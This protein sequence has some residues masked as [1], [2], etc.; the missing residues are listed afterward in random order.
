[1]YTPMDNYEEHRPMEIDGPSHQAPTHSTTPHSRDLGR[2][3][4]Q[5][6]FSLTSATPLRKAR[7]LT[8]S[9]AFII[10]S[11]R[12]NAEYR[13]GGST[14]ATLKDDPKP[15]IRRNL[16]GGSRL[17]S[18]PRNLLKRKIR[19]SPPHSDLILNPIFVQSEISSAF[20]LP[21]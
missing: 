9:G 13:N 4:S 7:P 1:V 18:L 10:D 12:V 2:S 6:L 20:I 8:R 19:I 11:A 14:V 16:E 15:T 3:A 5:R 17:I 21:P